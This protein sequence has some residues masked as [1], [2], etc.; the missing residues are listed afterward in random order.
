MLLA[1]TRRSEVVDAILVIVDK[2][3]KLTYYVLVKGNIDGL[4]LADVVKEVL[5]TQYSV[6]D[7]IV[8]DRESIFT[9]KF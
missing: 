9:S 1:K 4:G 3:S 2:L 8:S 5:L 7:S 6:L